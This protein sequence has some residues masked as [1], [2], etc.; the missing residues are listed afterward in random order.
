MEIADIIVLNKADLDGADRSLRHLQGALTAGSFEEGEW[1]PRVVLTV[2]AA[3]KPEDLQGID[4]LTE[5]IAEHQAY[6]RKSEVMDQV[7][8]DRVEQELGLIFKDEL[9]KI[10]FR[11][12][13]GTGKKREYI[14]SIIEQQNDPYSVVKEVLNN[15]LIPGE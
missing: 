13:R 14:E 8:Y 4:E 9:Q 12:L 6:L 7:K 10:I 11:G 3:N 15:Y 2:S 5:T 1:M